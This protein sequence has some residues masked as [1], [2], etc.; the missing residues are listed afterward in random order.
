M[1]WHS[2]LLCLFV[3]PSCLSSHSST[4]LQGDA[5]MPALLVKAFG[6]DAVRKGFRCTWCWKRESLKCHPLIVPGG[7]YVSGDKK[8]PEI[9]CS[10]GPVSSLITYIICISTNEITSTSS[11]HCLI[12]LWLFYFRSSV[13]SIRALF[14]FSNW[15]P[16]PCWT[17]IC[18]Y[19]LHFFESLLGHCMYFCLYGSKYQSV[20]DAH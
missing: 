14:C 16:E 10:L 12:L 17:Y 19:F 2:V 3:L 6:Q 20:S 8:S 9:L 13:L 15:K 7:T 5:S 1:K 18:Y 4:L 11:F